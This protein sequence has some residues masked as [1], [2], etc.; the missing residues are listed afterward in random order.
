MA[1]WLF[2]IVRGGIMCTKMNLKPVVA[3]KLITAVAASIILFPCL[4]FAKPT[5]P[6]AGPVPTVDSYEQDGG[7]VEPSFA[8]AGGELAPTPSIMPPLKDIPPAPMPY[9][10]DARAGVLDSGP[11]V[12][13]MHDPD[14]GETTEGGPSSEALP[15]EFGQGG[16]YAG[17][18]GGSGDG[19]LTGASF[20]TK[21]LITDVG[22]TPWRMNVKV[23]FRRG[24][25]WFVCSGALRDARTVQLAGRCV[26]EGSGGNWN[27]ETWVFPGWDGND[28]LPFISS[29]DEY[30]LQSYGAARGQI[31]ASWT[32]WTASGDWD[33]DWGIVELD[34]SVGFLTGWY[35]WQHRVLF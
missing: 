20:G 4:T 25:S 2:V 8:P 24:T 26:H 21:T 12:P 14:T 30:R 5:Y 17:A 6:P 1:G 35:G 3:A 33:F 13:V 18:D 11:G 34:R 10:P 15:L 22:S 27:D 7:L 19:E 31:L 32:G 29:G 23:A 16:F 28:N 9:P